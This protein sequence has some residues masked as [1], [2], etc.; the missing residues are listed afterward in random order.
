M[1]PC[2]VLSVFVSVCNVDSRHGQGQGHDGGDS[3]QSTADLTAFVSSKPSPAD[4]SVAY[5]EI[6]QNAEL[7]YCLAHWQQS[8]FQTMSDSIISKNILFDQA[9]GQSVFDPLVYL[10]VGDLERALLDEMGSRIDDLEKS[11]GELVKEA[12]VDSPP[13]PPTSSQGQLPPK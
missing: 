1:S 9:S 4:V 7:L 12:G 8:R 13:S 11:I 6:L 5:T 3:A 2:C 10:W